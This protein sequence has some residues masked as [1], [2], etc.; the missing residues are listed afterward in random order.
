MEIEINGKNF[1]IE[2]AESY[3]NRNGSHE[4]GIGISIPKEKKAFSYFVVFTKNATQLEPKLNI[5]EFMKNKSLA[6]VRK[7][8]EN[9]IFENAVILVKAESIEHY[10]SD[11]NGNKTTI[12]NF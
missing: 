4:F 5:E 9:E 6:E 11:G 1:A 10:L 3:G 8:L 12:L 2:Q 7:L